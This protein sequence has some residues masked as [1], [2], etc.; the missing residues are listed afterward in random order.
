MNTRIRRALAP[1]AL[2]AAVLGFAPAAVLAQEAPVANAADAPSAEKLFQKHLEAI[3]G[4]ERVKKIEHI[5]A[6]GSVEVA[7]AGMTMSIE[8]WQAAPN[9]IRMTMNLPG[10]GMMEQGFDGETGWMMSPMTGPMLLEGVQLDEMKQQAMVGRDA[11]W[12]ELYSS[13]ETTGKEAFAGKPAWAVKAVTKAG[14][15]QTIYF[16]AETGLQLGFKGTQA[17]DMGEVSAETV[18][19]EWKEFDGMKMPV[20]TEVRLPAMGMT[21]V[22]KIESVEFDEIPAEKFE[23]PEMIRKLKEAQKPATPNVPAGVGG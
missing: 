23:L 6:K 19:T 9:S 1:A 21:Q 7:A 3:G 4:L 17:T 8:T 22:L 10:M 14:S 18:F 2:A 16:D 13:L 11:K 20:V 15:E 12:K 5:H